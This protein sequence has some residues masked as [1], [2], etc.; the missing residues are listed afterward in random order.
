[1]KHK[2]GEETGEE[3]RREKENVTKILEKKRGGT[4]ED[5]G[6]RKQGNSNG[7]KQDRN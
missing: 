6:E 3:I 1:M 7:Q 2:R 5:K 4:E